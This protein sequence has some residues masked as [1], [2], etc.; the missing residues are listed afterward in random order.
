MSTIRDIL[1]LFHEEGLSCRQISKILSVSASTV[2]RSLRR[3]HSAGFSWPL[4]AD[5]DLEAL[6]GS[7]FPSGERGPAP[8]AAEHP[9]WDR[10]AAALDK[11]RAKRRVRMTRKRLWEA[12]RDDVRS[13]GGEVLSYSRFCHL[14]KVRREGS[15]GGTGKMVYEYFPG[16]VG[17]S[18]FSGKRLGLRQK[19]GSEKDVEIFV[20]VLCYSR[21]TYVEA[22]PDQSARSWC[23]AHRRAF[24]Y[25]GGVPTERWSIDNLKAGVIRPGREDW[26]LNPSFEECMGHYCVPVIPARKGNVQERALVESTVRAVQHRVLLPLQDMPFFSQ[27]AMNRAILAK[28]EEFNHCPMS[29]WRVSRR[30]RFEDERPFLRGLPETPWEWGEWIGRLVSP[31]D[32]V[33]FDRNHYS[34]P[35]GRPGRKVWVRAGERVVEVFAS[36]TGSRIAVHPRRSGVHQYV[37]EP[38]HMRPLHRRIRERVRQEASPRDYLEWLLREAANIGPEALDWA[39]CCLASREYPQHAFRTVRGMIDLAGK[40]DADALEAACARC[41]GRGWLSSAAVRRQ[42]SRKNR[43]GPEDAAKPQEPIPDHRNVRGPAAFRTQAEPRKGD[44]P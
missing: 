26:Q 40:H 41:R 9:D 35:Q 30:Q 39:R 34:V 18:D 44:R 13:R 19:D 4:P 17:L 22:V 15:C 27:G 24:E 11:P 42:L 33:T 12:Y 25:F 6:S 3:A 8:D 36:R 5:V 21:L 7:M 31:N 2:S 37:T 10:I 16:Q 23:M 38:H 1:R 43:A 28:L 29:T 14:L 32:H 20:A